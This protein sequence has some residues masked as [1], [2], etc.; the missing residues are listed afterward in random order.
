MTFSFQ[1]RHEVV[2]YLS[3]IGMETYSIFIKTVSGEE[4]SWQTYWK[5]LRKT[6][7]I[8]LITIAV[9]IAA[10]IRLSDKIMEAKKKTTVT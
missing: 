2:S 9:L 6:S 8:A 5:P 4:I 1:D 3:P 10:L 7:W